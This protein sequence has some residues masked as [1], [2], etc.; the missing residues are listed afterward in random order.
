MRLLSQIMKLRIF[1][2]KVRIY[3]V[4]LSLF[5][6]QLSFLSPAYSDF[7]LTPW[8][9]GSEKHNGLTRIYA[10]KE[11]MIL[12]G[13]NLGDWCDKSGV[14]QGDKAYG[15]TK[16]NK[17]N[18][19]FR[20]SVDAT[21]LVKEYAKNKIREGDFI[22]RSLGEGGKTRCHSREAK[23]PIHRPMLVLKLN[24]KES[25]L[26]PVADTY[27]NQ[28]TLSGLGIEDHFNFSDRQNAYLRFE[29][30]LSEPENIESAV[31]H[32]SVITHYGKSSTMGVFRSCYLPIQNEPDGMDGLS[33]GYIKDRGIEKHPAVVFA[34]D[35]DG[36]FRHNGPWSYGFD[37][38]NLA[39][40]DTDPENIFSPF[41][42]KAL[43]V[44]IPKNSTMGANMGYVF[45][46]GKKEEPESLFF[47]YYL[48]FGETWD[49]LTSGKLP[50]LS[51]TYNKA[52][53]GTRKSNGFNGWSARG[54]FTIMLAKNDPISGKIPIGSY[55]Y[56]ANQPKWSGEFFIWNKN[57]SGFLDKNKWYCIE[58]H[59]KLNTPGKKDGILKAW[60][61]GKIAYENNQLEYRKTSDLKIEKVWMNVYHGGK[62][63]AHKD[64]SLF[65]DNVVVATEYIGPC[66]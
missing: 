10:H 9:E 54:L 25:N 6:I 36:V 44:T 23:D 38:D 7:K 34:D 46:R 2:L 8:S 53:W 11:A 42:G 30:P 51:G 5:F 24:G 39:V 47:R 29:L 18:N 58:Q 13:H 35:F 40:V 32:L 27:T 31:L 65:I 15:H 28:S 33:C 4:I 26:F 62:T 56:H 14:P 48:R 12:W 45:K 57:Y 41:G 52:G 17:S 55:V 37:S 64:L 66:D 1:I 50:G 43:K 21:E 3:P 60:V 16:L 49:P 22:L 19:S 59:V 20:M 61:D 63:T